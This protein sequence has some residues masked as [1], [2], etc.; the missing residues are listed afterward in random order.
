MAK[1]IKAA[2]NMYRVFLSSLVKKSFQYTCKMS[3]NSNTMKTISDNLHLIIR[4]LGV[5]GTIY[6][7][8]DDSKSE[9]TYSTGIP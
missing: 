4:I 9:S 7:R 6:Y 2:E 3:F 1:K 8:R 5:F